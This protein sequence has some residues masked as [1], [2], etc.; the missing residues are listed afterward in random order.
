MLVLFSESG[1][2]RALTAT[3]EAQGY[4]GTDV[5]YQNAALLYDTDLGRCRTPAARSSGVMR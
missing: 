5:N 1:E 4:F 2:H 3:S